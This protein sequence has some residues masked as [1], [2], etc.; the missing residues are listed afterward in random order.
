MCQIFFSTT[1]V[2]LSTY[3]QFYFCKIRN[4]YTLDIDY[5]NLSNVNVQLF[6]LEII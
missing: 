5:I 1:D 2:E 3:K 4:V 6:M